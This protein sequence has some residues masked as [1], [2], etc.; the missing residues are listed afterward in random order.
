MSVSLLV[1]AFLVAFNQL[2]SAHAARSTKEAKQQLAAEYV[3]VLYHVN[4]DGLLHIY[5]SQHLYIYTTCGILFF[6]G[7]SNRLAGNLL[8]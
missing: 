8:I 7:Q 5:V 3:S 4:K 2:M 6:T 1:A